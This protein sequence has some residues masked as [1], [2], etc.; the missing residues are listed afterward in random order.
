MI[1]RRQKQ[2]INNHWKEIY[3]SATSNSIK[4]DYYCEAPYIKNGR[5]DSEIKKTDI[6][7]VE[8]KRVYS[9]RI[10]EELDENFSRLVNGFAALSDYYDWASSKFYLHKL[11]L[12]VLLVNS[13]DD[14]LI[15]SELFGPAISLSSTKDKALFVVTQNGGHL[16][17][18]EGGVVIPETV[19]WID[20]VIVEY[21]K[22]IIFVSSE[23]LY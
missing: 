15:P 8:E 6:P 16:G 11:E 1:T 4:W 19:T 7:A 3:P 10:L 18:F 13:S 12:P 20:R 22:S 17:F 21:I 14:P 2:I 9:S 5:S 23:G